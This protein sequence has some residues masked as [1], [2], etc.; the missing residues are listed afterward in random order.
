MYL[1]TGATGNVGRHLVDSLLDAGAA[2]R[3][4][5][6]D[7]ATARFPAGVDVVRTGAE[8]LD[9]VTALFLNHSAVPDGPEDLFGRARAH[10][11]RRVVLLSS[12]SVL[13]EDPANVIGALHQHLERAVRDSGLEWTLLRPGAFNTN[14]LQWAGQLRAE[15]VV[16]AAHG[17]ARSATIDERDIAAVAAHALLSD[18]LV[19][20]SP[21]LS[22]PE[23]LTPVDQVRLIGE[24]IGRPLRFEELSVD[25]ARAAMLAEHYPPAIADGLL[26]YFGRAV[27]HPDEVSPAVEDITGVPPRAFADWAEE[28]AAAFR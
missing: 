21:T 6:R 2:V 19:G 5:T 16:R 1:V 22:G 12:N 10:G 14:T 25:E 11:V 17:R 28:H 18:G 7:P 20:A 3:A 24:A 26:H 8:P 13:H 27:D 9:G 15:G 4:G 23:L